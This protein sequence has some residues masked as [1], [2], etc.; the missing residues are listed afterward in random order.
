MSNAVCKCGTVENARNLTEGASRAA[1]EATEGKRLE[2][3]NKF[4]CD[5]NLSRLED[6]LPLCVFACVCVLAA[7]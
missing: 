1:R 7:N 3:Q 4:S 2:T 6:E 5:F